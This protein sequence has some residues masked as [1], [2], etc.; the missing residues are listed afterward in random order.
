MVARTARVGWSRTR[1]RGCTTVP[2]VLVAVLRHVVVGPR[3]GVYMP[4]SRCADP[5]TRGRRSAF[6]PVV[7]LLTSALR[8]S[9]QHMPPLYEES[10][11]WPFDRWSASALAE[12]DWLADKSK[13]SVLCYPHVLVARLSECPQRSV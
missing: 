13:A 9:D 8:Y 2:G 12:A 7:L 5:Y 4:H 6:I 3:I 11:D 10:R 1:G